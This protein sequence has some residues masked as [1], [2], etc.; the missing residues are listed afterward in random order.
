MRIIFV[1]GLIDLIVF[2]AFPSGKILA[3]RC[4]ESALRKIKILSV[5]Y[6]GIFHGAR[7]TV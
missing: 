5:F 3:I 4:L 7:G 6:S 1:I 2:A